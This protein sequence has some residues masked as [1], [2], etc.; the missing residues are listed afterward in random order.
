MKKKLSNDYN[1]LDKLSNDYNLLD[2]LSN[3][4][5][6]L[7]KLSNYYNLLDRLSNNYNLLDKLTNDYNLFDKFSSYYNL[8]DKLSNDYNLLSNDNGIAIEQSELL[9]GKLAK[10]IKTRTFVAFC[11]NYNIRASSDNFGWKKFC[12][13]TIFFSAA[14]VPAAP[15]LPSGEYMEH[16]LAYV[17]LL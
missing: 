9:R 16:H 7:D 10:N 12:S 1:L 11:Q 17:F 2:K 6:L 14:L 4:Y 15:H 8:L 13:R 3:Y 5:N